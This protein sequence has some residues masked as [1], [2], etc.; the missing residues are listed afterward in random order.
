MK[1]VVVSSHLARDGGTLSAPLSPMPTVFVV[2]S[3][4]S[5]QFVGYSVVRS[6]MRLL[7]ASRVARTTE[8]FSL[9]R[10]TAD[11]EKDCSP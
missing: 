2:R 1:G 11:P 4:A 7:I 8:S 6:P 5:V 3:M 9:C 10:T